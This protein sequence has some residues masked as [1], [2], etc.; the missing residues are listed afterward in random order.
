LF[1]A[2]TVRLV[3]SD[4]SLVVAMVDPDG[5]PIVSRACGVNVLD[6]NTGSVR[7]LLDAED[8]PL[9][10]QLADGAVIALTTGN[11]RTHEAKQ[12]KGHVVSIERATSVDDA[13]ALEYYE[14]FCDVV[15]ESDGI[16][17]AAV[18]RLVPTRFLACVIA[19]DEM[20]DQ[21]PGPGAGAPIEGET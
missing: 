14:A 20:F 8:E 3:E 9:V 19:F 21:T 11:V 13:R 6:P 18:E 15:Q 2:E 12:F 7:L 16:D 5:A 4:V 17:R 10:A 1:D